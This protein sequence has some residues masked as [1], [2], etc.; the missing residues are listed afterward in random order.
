MRGKLLSEDTRSNID[1]IKEKLEG[2]KTLTA[3]A[4]LFYAFSP[5]PSNYLFIAY[6]LTML[7]LRV[8]A[9]PFF[10]G[11]LIGYNFWAH[12]GSAAARKLAVE[13]PETYMSVYFIVV[14]L[15]CLAL[16]YVFTRVDW[17]ALLQ[18]RKL[19][20][21]RKKTSEYSERIS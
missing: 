6:G 10:L 1:A 13:A 5:L 17:R 7:E 14:Q 21:A 20:W 2:K 4:S 11:R 19:R 16:I 3:G 18:E 12:L 9:L 15:A 8:L